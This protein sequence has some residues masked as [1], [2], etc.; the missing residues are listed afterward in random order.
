[1]C[2]GTRLAHPAQT[3]FLILL[4]TANYHFSICKSKHVLYNPDLVMLFA[5]VQPYIF[6][7]IYFWYAVMKL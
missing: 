3:L 6:A 2:M 7:A 5:V 1:M 4:D